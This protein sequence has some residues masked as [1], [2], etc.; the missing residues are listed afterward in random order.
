VLRAPPPQEV[1]KA[2]VKRLNEEEVQ[3]TQE[4]KALNVA[5]LAWLHE[6]KLLSQPLRDEPEVLNNRYLKRLLL[7]SG[8]FAEVWKAFDLREM[9]DVALKIVRIKESQPSEV[10][11]RADATGQATNSHGF[12]T[13]R[14]TSFCAARAA[15]T[16]SR[17]SSART[18]TLC[19]CWTS[20]T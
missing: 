7:G 1:R 18:R 2:R 4:Y 6:A 5:R 11:V 9:K 3:I 15:S 10:Q 16:R 14:R 17:K 19:S 8:G 13:P 12:A 20:S